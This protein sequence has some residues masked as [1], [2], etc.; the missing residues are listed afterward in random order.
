L[1]R[2]DGLVIGIPRGPHLGQDPAAIAGGKAGRADAEEEQSNL[3]HAEEQH[4]DEWS[5]EGN[6]RHRLAAPPR[7][8]ALIVAPQ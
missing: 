4:Q 5:D 2:L 3:D 7:Q 6:L 8:S 1:D